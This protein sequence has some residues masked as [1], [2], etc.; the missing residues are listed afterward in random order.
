MTLT[1]TTSFPAGTACWDSL[2]KVQIYAHE[3]LSNGFSI[4]AQVVVAIQ[5]KVFFACCGKLVI[6]SGNAFPLS[7]F[8]VHS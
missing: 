1:C 5:Y 8:N 4:T 6:C 2:D 3:I 7:L